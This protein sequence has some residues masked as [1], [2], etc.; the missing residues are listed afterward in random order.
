MYIY[1]DDD[2]GD[3]EENLSEVK[4]KLPIPYGHIQ[5]I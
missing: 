4:G 3:D 2:D 5:N 1:D